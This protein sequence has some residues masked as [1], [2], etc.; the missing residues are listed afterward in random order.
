[1]APRSVALTLALLALPPAARANEP[2]I[3][4]EITAMIRESARDSLDRAAVAER[5]GHPLEAEGLYRRALDADPGLLTA[6]LGYARMLDARGRRAE[7]REALAR[8]PRRAWAADE[9]AAIAYAGALRSLGAVDEALAALRDRRDSAAAT[10]A[11]AEGAAQEGR[12]PEAL[13]AAR[14]LVELTG[15]GAGGREARVLVRALTRLV[16]EADAVRTP[17]APTG[18]RR[19]LMA[20]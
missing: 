5:D 10:R 18:F 12:F 4:P 16:A 17:Y 1:M 9:P 6:H 13:A 2:P 11:L 15:D 14:R 20:D 19:A 8:A 3:S 7:A